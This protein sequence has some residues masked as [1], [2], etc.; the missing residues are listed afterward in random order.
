MLVIKDMSRKGGCVYECD[1]CKKRLHTNIEMRYRIIAYKAPRGYYRQD[2]TWDLCERCYRALC[3]GIKK[4]VK[5]DDT[6]IQ[7]TKS[8]N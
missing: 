2:K 3:R 4:G 5:K 8:N 7:P 1:R 6:N